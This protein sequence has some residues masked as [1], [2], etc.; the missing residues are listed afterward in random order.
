[1]RVKCAAGVAALIATS[2]VWVGVAA[3]TAPAAAI[4]PT[5]TFSPREAPQ[6]V[7]EDSPLW[8]CTMMGNHICGPGNSNGVPAG[9]YDQGGV[10][11]KPWSR[12]D[13]P[14]MDDLWANDYPAD[15]TGHRPICSDIWSGTSG[16]HG[17][18]QGLVTDDGE[19]F[20]KFWD[21]RNPGTMIDCDAERCDVRADGNVVPVGA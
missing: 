18:P 19:I 14:R 4:T 3:V 2:A 6:A 9:C 17:D 1:M 8:D 16:E 21:V 5:V 12:Y 7:T 15:E 13:D 20:G 11:V 10:M